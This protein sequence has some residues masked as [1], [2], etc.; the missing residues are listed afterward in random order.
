MHTKFV[1]WLW[2]HSLAMSMKCDTSV[3][4]I[5]AGVVKQLLYRHTVSSSKKAQIYRLVAT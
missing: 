2:L 3:S 5:L 1:L 4:M